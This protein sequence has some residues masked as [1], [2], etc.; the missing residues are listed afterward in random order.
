[1]KKNIKEAFM[2]EILWDVNEYHIKILGYLPAFY[3][4]RPG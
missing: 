2:P 1:M 3:K 4:Y